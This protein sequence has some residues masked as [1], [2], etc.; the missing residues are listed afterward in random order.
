[1]EDDDEFGDLYTDV[2]MPFSSTSTTT[3]TT[4]TSSSVAPQPHQPS[5]T[6]AHLH[7]PIDLNLQS[8]DDDHTL[9]GHQRPIPDTQT[10]APFKSPPSPAAAAAPGS[11]PNRDSVSEPLI[12][13][14]K[15]EP[16]D[17]KEVKFD[18]EE[19][20]VMELKISAQR[21]R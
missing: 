3:A 9:F 17:G 18:I 12:L 5:P 10:L 6:P 15:Q 8:Q 13:D 7:H 2:L 19:G 11:I 4:T 21:T 20:V 14:S 16:P 1:M